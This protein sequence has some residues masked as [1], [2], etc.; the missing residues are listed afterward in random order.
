MFSKF[1]VQL[2]ALLIMALILTFFGCS[3]I[4]TSEDVSRESQLPVI[5]EQYGIKVQS[6]RL[7][8]AGTMLDFRYQ[9]VDPDKAVTMVDRTNKPYLIDQA[10]GLKVNVP[11]PA[12]LGP[13]RATDKYGKP[14]VG[15]TYFVLFGNPGRFI[16]SGSKVT[17]VIG[18]FRAEDLVVQ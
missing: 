9:I 2:R 10:S 4:K 14:K 3:T 6:L 5:E 12:K 13:L 11:S 15:R 1:N 18:E 17:V 16:K 8:A 7:S